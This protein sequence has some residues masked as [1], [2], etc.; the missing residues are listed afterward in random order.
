MN[1]ILEKFQEEIKL[2][3]VATCM[4]LLFDRYIQKAIT[5]S[6]PQIVHLI[7]E[8]KRGLNNNRPI[9]RVSPLENTLL[10]ISSAHYA[11]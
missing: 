1:T 2:E 4:G 6:N 3:S 7:E 11:Q 9:H 5:N 8:F 10:K